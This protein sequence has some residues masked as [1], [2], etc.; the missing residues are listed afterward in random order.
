MSKTLHS[1]L[2]IAPEHP[3]EYRNWVNGV[4]SVCF[5]GA[6]VIPHTSVSVALDLPG[7]HQ[8]SSQK[9]WG[10]SP[11][12]SNHPLF[13]RGGL[14][15]IR[16]YLEKSVGR[17]CSSTFIFRANLKSVFFSRTSPS[18]NRKQLPSTWIKGKRCQNPSRK[19]LVLQPP[20][21]RGVLS[22]SN[23]LLGEIFSFF[24]IFTPNF[25]VSR[26]NL[27]FIFF[28]WVGSTNN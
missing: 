21:F 15:L 12:H 7:I 24:L 11:G 8:L 1:W 28:R 5:G 26:S 25:G 17:C 13:F 23:D 20:F 22:S 19:D 14:N 6:K 18:Q 16:F 4:W 9:G 2:E 27:T 3:G 10:C